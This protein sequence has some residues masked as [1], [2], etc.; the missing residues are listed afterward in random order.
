MFIRQLPFFADPTTNLLMNQEQGFVGKP[1][2]DV[3]LQYATKQVDKY[4][5]DHASHLPPEQKDEIRQE[6]LFRVS[7]A[8]ADIDPSRGWKAFVQ[9]HSR[10]AVLD[11][12]RDGTGFK[13]TKWDESNREIVPELETYAAGG[14]EEHEDEPDE[15]LVVQVPERKKFKQRLNQRVVVVSSD[16]NRALDVEEIA[17]IFGVHSEADDSN[18]FKPKW[19]LVARMAAVDPEIHLVAKILRGFTQTELAP[20]FGV[21]REMLSQRI[22]IFFN[23]L[24]DPQFYHSPWIRQII[25]AFGLEDMYCVPHKER[26]DQ[27]LGWNNDPIDLDS[28][29]SLSLMTLFQQEEF[30]F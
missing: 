25:Y 26:G 15:A 5:K 2:L 4:L 21:T 12:L 6:A 30:N 16:D 3:V 14:D 18:I 8:Y 11:Y 19:E 10:G 27:G 9:M 22:R 17:G 28:C 24:D 29:N 1:D 23:K 13:E 7:N 20:G